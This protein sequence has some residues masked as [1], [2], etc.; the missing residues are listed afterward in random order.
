MKVKYLHDTI[1]EDTTYPIIG[2]WYSLDSSL[3]V[4]V[5]GIKTQYRRHYSWVDP[6]LYTT[7]EL[8]T[9]YHV[10]FTLSLSYFKFNAVL[11]PLPLRKR[12]I[13]AITRKMGQ[14]IPRWLRRNPTSIH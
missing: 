9:R 6:E 3:K 4:R 13:N 11:L 7:V 5:L 10:P 14:W 8:D 12:L 2:R 1:P